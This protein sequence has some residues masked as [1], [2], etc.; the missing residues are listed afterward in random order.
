MMTGEVTPTEYDEPALIERAAAGQGPAQRMLY[1]RYHT[2]A[3]RLAYLL[4]QDSGDAEEI[5]QD[6]FVYALANISRYSATRGTFWAW[7]RVILVSRCRNLRRRRQFA[8]VSLD[9][10]EGGARLAASSGAGDDPAAVAEKRDTR[11]LIWQ[12]LREV[13]P[14]ARDALILRFYEGLSYAEIGESLDCTAEAARSRV[15]HG[16][17][18]LRRLLSDR[19]VGVVPAR[20]LTGLVGA[21]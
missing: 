9:L 18:Q 15:A 3:F 11:R 14:G 7:L 8:L 21:E 17:V 12:A 19:G 5:V 20:A 1:E 2:R 6:A 4:L 13:S 10:L 16:K